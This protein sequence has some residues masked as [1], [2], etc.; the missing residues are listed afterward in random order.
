MSQSKSDSSKDTRGSLLLGTF[1]IAAYEIRIDIKLSMGLSAGVTVSTKQLKI[2]LMGLY[3]VLKM[4]I[5]PC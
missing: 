1:P 2:T 5:L 4:R 3:N